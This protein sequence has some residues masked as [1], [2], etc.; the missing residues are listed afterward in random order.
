MTS[1]VL[2]TLHPFTGET[3]KIVKTTVETAAEIEARAGGRVPIQ[4]TASVYAVCRFLR[5]MERGAH[6]CSVPARPPNATRRSATHSPPSPSPPAWPA[7]SGRVFFYNRI[8]PWTS[9]T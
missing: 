4:V 1:I 6:I 9:N 8:T 7:S 5:W 2:R 3:S